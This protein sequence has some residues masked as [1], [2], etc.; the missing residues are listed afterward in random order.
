MLHFSMLPLGRTV[1]LWRITRHLTQEELARLAAIPR[2]N[3]SSLEQGKREVNL[4]TLRNLASALGI[5]AGQLVDGIPPEREKISEGLNRVRLEGIADC[6]TGKRVRL[7][8]FD[9]KIASLLTPLIRSR[10]AIHGK[11]IRLPRRNT[12]NI[13]RSWLLL[14]SLL[15][16]QEISSLIERVEG[17]FR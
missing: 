14:R 9:M 2:P 3:L 8:E 12:R 15:S 16:P 7:S 6:V 5:T 13:E 1:Y 4:S 10:L 17:R 11:R